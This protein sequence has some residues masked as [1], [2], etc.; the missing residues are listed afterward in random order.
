[1]KIKKDGFFYELVKGKT[2][3][4]NPEDPNHTAINFLGN[5]WHTIWV[6]SLIPLGI[7]L[8]VIV[9]VLERQQINSRVIGQILSISLGIY[10]FLLFAGIIIL[11]IV[12]PFTKKEWR[13]LILI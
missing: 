3:M 10:S 4:S 8:T 13:K 1:M 6:Y 12:E 7:I 5:V 11:V 2:S 9:L